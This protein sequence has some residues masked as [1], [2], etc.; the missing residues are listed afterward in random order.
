MKQIPAVRAIATS[1]L[2]ASVLAACSSGSSQ[3]DG[4]GSGSAHGSSAQ[5]TTQSAAPT[6]R[7]CAEFHQQESRRTPSTQLNLVDPNL[8]GMSPEQREQHMKMMREK[9][10]SSAVES[11]Y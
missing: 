1:A 10:G 4:S 3:G 8:S 11:R 5:G 6:A 2:F 7:E 9:C